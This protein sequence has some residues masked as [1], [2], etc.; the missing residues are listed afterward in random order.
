MARVI[1][2]PV[3]LLELTGVDFRE[4][5]VLVHTLI[6][7]SRSIQAFAVEHAGRHVLIAHAVDHVM[8]RHAAPKAVVP[9]FYGGWF[10][11]DDLVLGTANIPT[12]EAALLKTLGGADVAR[13][14]A[15]ISVANFWTLSKLVKT[16]LD[17]QA[18]PAEVYAYPVDRGEV[19]ERFAQALPA[20]A[21]A[22][23][24][25]FANSRAGQVM[26]PYLEPL[27]DHRFELLQDALWEAGVDHFVVSSPMVVQDLTGIPFEECR[28]ARPI[29]VAC[30]HGDVVVLATQ[31]IAG[32][33]AAA[34]HRGLAHAAERYLPRGVVGIEA[35]DLD[36]G[37]FA[38]LGLRER[39]V[40]NS[41]HTLRAWRER[42]TP[43]DLPFYAILARAQASSIEATLAVA[44]AALDAPRPIMEEELLPSYWQAVREYERRWELP[45][46]LAEY[47]VD[48][49]TSDHVFPSAL[50]RR[51][52]PPNTK[53][54]RFDAALIAVDQAGLARA[55]SD[56]SRHLVRTSEG[57][58]LD[59]A[60][61]DIVRS[62]VLPSVRPGL[63]GH[64]VWT[65]SVK[66]M[67]LEQRRWESLGL[68]PAGSPPLSS[69]YDRDAGHMFAKQTRPALMHSR[70]CQVPVRAGL[71][72]TVELVWPY[73]G[74]IF[75]IEDSFFVAPQET[76]NL[77]IGG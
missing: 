73:N 56:G 28:R 30:R 46:T 20:A 47:F 37:T 57:K 21:A 49:F 7:A 31:P 40:R 8:V 43:D 62:R 2:D 35:E 69:V 19:R 16:E 22:A 51:P 52:I 64:D 66:H 14:T 4:T 41:L 12:L 6:D 76:V 23:G 26:A 72:G 48:I 58:A 74:Y 53:T 68:M 15:D 5:S 70:G 77:S 10:A 29:A 50:V 61:D 3:A 38:A 25:V 63:T 9:L 27:G 39:T 67:E 59:A 42:R 65:M 55:V 11:F 54:I 71:V 17:G 44:K 45:F 60:L 36:M 34:T 33:R 13:C 32:R 24:R 1:T 75:G 18:G